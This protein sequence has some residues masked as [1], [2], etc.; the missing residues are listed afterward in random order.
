MLQ[1]FFVGRFDNLIQEAHAMNSYGGLQIAGNT[2]ASIAGGTA[3]KHTQGWAAHNISQHGDAAVTPSV[4]NSRLTLVQGVYQ[5]TGIMSVETEGVGASGTS[6]D[7]IGR[8]KLKLYQG[9]SAVSGAS[10]E[11]DFQATDRPQTIVIQDI[12]EITKAQVDAGT[13]YVELWWDATD[14]SGN[15]II[16][17]DGKLLAVKLH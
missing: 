14:A 4:A 8:M 17:G 10:G 15:D 9:G 3:A 1:A 11:V 5:V 2:T 7:A 6:G 13:N 16:V 12:I